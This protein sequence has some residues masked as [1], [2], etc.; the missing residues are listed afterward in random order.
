[1]AEGLH[2][3]ASTT[4]RVRAE[5]QASQAKTRALATRN[6]LNPKTVAKWRSR[7]GTADAAM[8]LRQPRSS[9]LTKAEEAIVVEFRRRALLPHVR[10][11][12]ADHHPLHQRPH[13]PRLLRGE[14]MLPKRIE[15]M[16]R[17]LDLALGEVRRFLLA[18]RQMPITI[19]GSRSSGRTRSTT[20]AAISAAAA[21]QGASCPATVS[22]NT[23]T[24]ATLAPPR[25]SQ[26]EEVYSNWRD[27]FGRRAACCSLWD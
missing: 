16:Q 15:P 9:V 23:S 12:R 14:Q 11:S 20:A 25:G 21:G 19:F 26:S 17:I 7:T 24:V 2:G 27:Y 5:L 22:R 18:A 1:M 4:P 3:S 13:N 6:G 10:A 8:G